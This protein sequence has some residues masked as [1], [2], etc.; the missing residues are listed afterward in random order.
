VVRA[1]NWVVL[2]DLI[3]DQP[4][5]F[6][7]HSSRLYFRHSQLPEG[8]RFRT[9]LQL[10]VD[11]LRQADSVSEVPL[12]A[13]FDGGY[14]RKAVIQPCLRPPGMGRRIQI[15]TRPRSDARLYALVN[16]PLE[17]KCGRPRKWGKRLPRPRDFAQWETPWEEGKA[18]VYGQP[19]WFRCKRLPCLWAITGADQPM[20]A[21][22]F[23]VEGFSKPWFL[24]TSAVELPSAQIIQ[25]YT[26]RYRQEDAFRDQKQL[27]GMEECRAWTKEPIL[28]TFQVQMLALTLLRLMQFRLDRVGQWWLRTPWYPQKRHASILDLRRL[29]WSHRERF[30]QLVQSPHEVRKMPPVPK[31]RR[32]RA[33]HAA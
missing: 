18:S 21:M 27:L 6:L 26:A 33:S 32:S 17:R 15:L 5:W 10:G 11:L 23:W 1:H 12:L 3:P 25:A 19:R 31:S 29:F 9:K 2:G 28:R 4:W 24:I 22:V 8:E 7:P 16:P 20:C 30:S 14:A 13:I